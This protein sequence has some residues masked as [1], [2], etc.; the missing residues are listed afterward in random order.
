MSLTKSQLLPRQTTP[1]PNPI[2]VKLVQKICQRKFQTK[3][4]QDQDIQIEW[5]SQNTC[6]M[7]P[8]RLKTSP[9]RL[10]EAP[11]QTQDQP[12]NSKRLQNTV[13]AASNF[14]PLPTASSSYELWPETFWN[15]TNHTVL[16]KITSCL[17][18]FRILTS[19][20][21]LVRHCYH[22]SNLLLP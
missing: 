16:S 2:H 12:K 7:P 22:Q 5:G 3:I 9:R 4:Y 15:H 10:E 18:G 17:F 21:F 6:H 8:K 14:V 20:A 11:K 1:K 19:N 13:K